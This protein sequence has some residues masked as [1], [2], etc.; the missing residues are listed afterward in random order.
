LDAEDITQ[1]VFAEVFESIHHFRGQSKLSTWIYRITLTKCLE[2]LRSRKRVKRSAVILSLFGKEQQINVTSAE[3]FYHPGIRLE[4]KELSAIL[5]NAI[6]KLPLNQR[7]AFTLHKIENLSYAELSEVMG[8]SL[9]SVE[10][11]MFRAKKNLKELLESYY[12]QN[13]K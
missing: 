7:T 5:F 13:I 8:V 12:E 11:L 4:N 10:S 9:S 3:P 1:E 2:L 6:S